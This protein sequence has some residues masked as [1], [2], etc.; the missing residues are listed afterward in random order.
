MDKI[1]IT[2]VSGFLG[3]HIAERFIKSGY[4]VISFKR[5]HTDFWR[6]D[7][8]FDAITWIDIESEDWQTLVIEAKPKVII[9]CAWFGVGAKD[10]DDLQHQIGNLN[11]L[12]ALLE[13]GNILK[14]KKFI[15]FGSQAEY[16][17]FEG[18]INEEST[19]KPN[20]AYGI[21]KSLASDC[22]KHFCD[23]NG[24][25]WYWLRLFS[26]FGE[27]E[28]ADWFIPMVINKIINGEELN[29]TPGEQEY[30]YMYVKDLSNVVLDITNSSE[31]KSGLYNLSSKQAYSL[32]SVIERILEI[33]NP[34]TSSINYGAIPYRP[35]QPMLIK[36]SMIKLENELGPIDEG[37]F[38]EN[39]NKTVQYYIERRKK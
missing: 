19:V 30:A 2:G 22:V 6:C 24:I 27:K 28:G 11:L 33:V 32:K 5:N 21:S 37:S 29:M 10:R 3:S 36:G 20:S 8:F 23:Y 12:S 35:N 16:G 13:I 34:K 4:K 18:E 25:D 26:F 38:E 14:I 39:L 9:H 15:S 31:I 7:D 17:H 1:L